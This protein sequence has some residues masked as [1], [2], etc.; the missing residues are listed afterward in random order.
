MDRRGFFRK[1]LGLAAAAPVA[2]AA[3]GEKAAGG[4]LADCMPVEVPPVPMHDLAWQ[5]S[6]CEFITYNPDGS[7]AERHKIEVR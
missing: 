1:A 2:A 7:V 3:A 5:L 4:Y 6:N